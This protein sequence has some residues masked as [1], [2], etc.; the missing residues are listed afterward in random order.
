MPT[1]EHEN[2]LAN[3]NAFNRNLYTPENVREILERL[4]DGETLTRICK[5][6]RQGVARVYG[7]FPRYATVYH[8]AA[9]TNAQFQP[10]FAQPFAEA[11]LMQGRAWIESTVDIADTQ[12]MGE[13]TTEED[14]IADG[15]K[16][17]VKIRVV[18]K[19]A[20]AHRALRIETRLKAAAKLNPQL[21][22]DRLQQAIPADAD[23]AREA[24]RLII[25][26]GLPDNEPPPPDHGDTP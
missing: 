24:P 14:I 4:E 25:E 15:L 11:K 19:D 17:G 23:P 22:A 12:E 10:D 7:G 3:L 1:G 2:S 9:P 6:D 18:K 16:M 26:G 21:W 13:E 8:W 20:T 5:F